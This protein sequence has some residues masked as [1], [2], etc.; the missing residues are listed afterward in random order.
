MD[1]N[2]NAVQEAFE[3]EAELRIWIVG[4]VK[5]ACVDDR[6]QRGKL[7]GGGQPGQEATGNDAAA[8]IV[9]VLSFGVPF[10]SIPN[11]PLG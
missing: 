2:T 1:E 7:L 8:T 9:L 6:P 11:A 4:L 5:H 3:A 10:V